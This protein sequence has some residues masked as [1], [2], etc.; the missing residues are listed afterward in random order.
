MSHTSSTRRSASASSTNNSAALQ[1][2]TNLVELIEQEVE[3]AQKEDHALTRLWPDLPEVVITY[4]PWVGRPDEDFGNLIDLDTIDVI[5]PAQM[6]LHHIE[7]L[8]AND[9][10]KLDVL[11]DELRLPTQHIR[12]SG[13]HWIEITKDSHEALQ[14]WYETHEHELGQA[15]TTHE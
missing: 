7:A 4:H 3:Q 9:S 8:V 13:P 11:Q 5:L 15:S 14:R 1:P 12:G 2:P 10:T 6:T